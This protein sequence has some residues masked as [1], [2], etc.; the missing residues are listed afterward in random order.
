MNTLHGIPMQNLDRPS[1]STESHRVDNP[2]DPEFYAYLE[3]LNNLRLLSDKWRHR[4]N[5]GV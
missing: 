3:S 4:N 1:G 2:R 5:W